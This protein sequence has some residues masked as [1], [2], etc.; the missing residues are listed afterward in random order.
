MVTENTPG[1]D[2]AMSEHTLSQPFVKRLERSRTD[3]TV[4]GV[5]GGLGRYFDMTPAV[6]RL[7]FVVLTLLGGAGV[8]VY[9]AAVLIMPPEGKSSSIAE[10]VIAERA[11]HPAR[12]V[13]LGLVAVALLA[14]LS[15]ASTWPLAGAGWI[16]LLI[17]GLVVLWATRERR[18]HRIVVAVVS[19]LAVGLVA[20]VVAV[21]AAFGWFNVS[22]SDGVGKQ[23]YVPT[24]IQDVRGTYRLGIGNLRVDLSQLPANANLHVNARVGIGKLRVIVPRNANVVVDARAKA[25]DVNAFDRHANGH[26]ATVHTGTNGTIYLD[27]EVG[28]GRVDVERAP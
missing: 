2:G 11:D 15:R 27:A 23:T 28:A 13:A 12:L 14:F 26:N 22:L 1:H 18:A 24:T 16:F 7:G 4:A 5:C 9:I 25:G 21:S 19:L 3:R 8:L 10:D 6:F 20:A 17:A